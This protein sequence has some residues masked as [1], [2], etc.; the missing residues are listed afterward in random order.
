MHK[1]D[2]TTRYQSQ[3]GAA[4]YIHDYDVDPTKREIYLV[5]REESATG[6]ADAGDN[7]PG[8]DWMLANRFIRNIRMLQSMGSEAIIIHMKTPGGDWMEGMAIYQA[9]QACPNHVTIINYA[10]A[11]SMSSI[12]FQAAD[13]RLMLPHS[14]FMMHEGDTFFGG[15]EKQS[16]SWIEFSDRAC[17][18]IMFDIYADKMAAAPRWQ[19]KTKKQI[20]AWVKREMNNKEEVYFSAI[21]TVEHGLADAIFGSD[22]EYDWESL[23]VES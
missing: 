19:D 11:R 7:E 14:W 4:D 18:P 20:V 10:A 17:K 15:T 6:N 1:S 3:F 13:Q 21:E 22:G 23:R 16:R 9:I 5:S 12:I 8:V 2:K